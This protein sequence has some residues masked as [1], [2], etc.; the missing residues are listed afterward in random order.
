MSQFLYYWFISF[1]EQVSL[2][3]LRRQVTNSEVGLEILVGTS[4]GNWGTDDKQ[5]K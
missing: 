5:T 4:Q 1:T 2:A 3:S